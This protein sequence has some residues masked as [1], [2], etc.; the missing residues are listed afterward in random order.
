MQHVIP[1]MRET[2]PV[3]IKGK[4]VDAPVLRVNGQDIV[5]KGRWIKI[6]RM[7]DEDWVENEVADPETCIRTFGKHAGADIFCFSQKVPDATPRHPYPMEMRSIAVANVAD[8]KEWLRKL[9]H[10]TRTNIKRAEKRGVVVKVRSFDADVIEGIR[11]VQ[12]ETPIRQ[13]RPF[14]HYG[15]TYEQVRRDHGAFL[16]HCDFLCAYYEDEFIGFL[17]LVYRGG[18]AS[19]L[20]MV[21]KIAHYDKRTANALLAKAAEICA[22]KGIPYL[23]Y[24]RFNYGNKG[25]NPLREFKE[26][27]G[28]IEMPLPTYYIPLTVWG[29]FCVATK[30]YRGWM[31]I[32]P[33]CA[34]TTAVKLRA[35][36]HTRR[37]RHAATSGQNLSMAS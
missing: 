30:L 2:M 9:P 27:N 4:W 25:D 36:W 15:K 17:K 24:D 28:F 34:I 31:G 37:N 19:I 13:G 12:N 6:A 5:T 11:E 7:H 14:P 16:D 26:R 29:R 32:L 22:G 20:Q 1:A 10:S 23:T 3:S 33:H 21:V 8:Y 18:V 35:K